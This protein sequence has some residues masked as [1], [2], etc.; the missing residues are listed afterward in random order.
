MIKFSQFANSQGPRETPEEMAQD[1]IFGGNDYVPLSDTTHL[2]VHLREAIMPHESN[3]KRII[4]TASNEDGHAGA[5]KALVIPRHT[6]YGGNKAKGM[7]HINQLRAKVYGSENRPPLS[8]G[9][10]EKIHKETLDEHFAKP[11]HEQLAA[12]EAALGRLKE[13]GHLSDD[14]LTTDEGEKTDTVKHE[15]DEQGRNFRAVSSKGVAGHAMY[16]S[17]A[18]ENEKHYILNTCPGQTVG[19]G[20]GVDSSGL[21]DTLKGTCFAPRAEQQY[22]GAAVRRAC[23]E[24][25]KHDPAMTK[26]WIIAHT[27]SLR[28]GA[29]TADKKNQR[30]LFRPNVLDETDRTSR[31]V[32]KHLNKQR[33]GQYNKK[34]K[35]QGLPPIIGNSY[36]KT[37]ELHDPENNY[38]VTHSNVGP[39]VKSGGLIP[40]NIG[41][42]AQRIRST[43]LAT[44]AAGKDFVNDEGNKTPPKNSYMVMNVKRDSPLDKSFQSTVN[45]IKYWSTGKDVSTLSKE[46]Q[47]M[48]NE[49]HFDG[50]GNKT[51]EDKAHYGH[52][53]VNGKRYEYQRQHVLHPRLVN[54]DGHM[55]PTDSRFMD[56]KFLPANRFMTKTGKKA[57]AIL[58]TTPTTS[59]SDL[60][61]HTIFTHHVD[62]QT[63]EKAKSNGG[64][65]EVDSPEAQEAAAGRIYA[66]PQPIHFA[67]SKKKKASKPKK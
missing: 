33:A 30:F 6:W 31:Y 10:I 2:G 55:I 42:D 44:N 48:G 67:A 39:K 12:E 53:T 1:K 62:E 56:D 37:N 36:G 24:Q 11:I 20:G 54:V 16:T 19:C 15:Y 59:T 27:G 5:A 35:Q 49:A 66:A 3:P 45:R 29:E 26:D 41:R 47:A 38:Y 9:Q 40:E 60:Q 32:I 17:G 8:L 22:V 64:E 4:V 50:Q 65:Y 18:G 43:I 14:A 28:R 63:I 23:H 7:S 25:A 52:V 46:D 51:T 58:V 61:H 57:G 21:A 13:A 34:M